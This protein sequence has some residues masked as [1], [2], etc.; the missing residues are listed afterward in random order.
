MRVLFWGTPA[1]AVPCLDALATAG[2]ELVGVVSQPDRRRG[3][4]GRLQPSAVKAR[5]HELGIPVWTPRHIRREPLLQQQLA[6]LGAEVYVIVAFGQLLPAEVL[7]QPPLG[8]WNG[9][10][11]LL[12]R[13]R[14]AAPIQ[15]ALLEG[16]DGTGVGIMAMEATLDTGPVLLQRTLTIGV[17]ENATSL[18]A[19]LSHLTATL[20]LDALPVIASRRACPTPQAI[21]GVSY[22][23]MLGKEDFR[24]HWEQTALAVHRRVMGVHPHA[25]TQWRGQRL[26]ILATVPLL[27]AL[28]DTLAAECGDGVAALARQPWPTARP[29]TVLSVRRSQGLVVAT[30][31]APL[32]VQEAQLAGR[33]PCRGTP[34]L[35]VLGAEESMGFDLTEAPV[36]ARS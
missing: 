17:C 5:A 31:D 11:S 25:A 20:L 7:A 4:G 32:L 36:R 12:P 13:W 2:H 9:H 6:D 19:R 21:Q 29:G 10:A 8:C 35:Q 26:K 24:I 1:F 23:R 22:A 34:L 15:W 14:G 3:R 30:A 33:R 28:A 18:S 27:P 16:D